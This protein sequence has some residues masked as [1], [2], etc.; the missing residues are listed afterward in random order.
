MD[1][2]CTNSRNLIVYEGIH[3]N[4]LL[5]GGR[6]LEFTDNLELKAEGQIKFDAARKKT[7]VGVSVFCCRG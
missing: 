7:I 4:W 6:L 1:M 2:R 3:S 5:L